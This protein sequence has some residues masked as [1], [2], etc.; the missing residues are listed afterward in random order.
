MQPLELI[1]LGVDLG[2]KRMISPDA[3]LDLPPVV[4]VWLV[5]PGYARDILGKFCDARV[6]GS[7]IVGDTDIYPTF[8]NR[9][10]YV[11]GADTEIVDAADF[12]HGL[13][14]MKSFKLRA[15]CVMPKGEY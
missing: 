5:G 2:D 9:E 14:V 8:L 13:W 4:P 12:V 6:V 1:Q 15:V 10:L 11:I 3:K 7:A